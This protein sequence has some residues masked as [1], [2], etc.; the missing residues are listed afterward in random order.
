MPNAKEVYVCYEESA[1]QN[2]VEIAFRLALS[3]SG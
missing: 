2:M 1:P 3:A